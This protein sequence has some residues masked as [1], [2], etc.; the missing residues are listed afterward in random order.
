MLYKSVHVN[1]NSIVP[2]HRAIPAPSFL[3]LSSSDFQLSTLNGL[4][5]SLF[6]ATLTNTAQLVE[7]STT[8]SPAFATLT[9]FAP[10]NFFVCHSYKK[11]PGV[12]IQMPAPQSRKK[13]NYK[14]ARTNSAKD[15][16]RCAHC[17]PSGRRCKMPVAAPGQLL[18][19]MHTQEL[20]RAD[21]LNLREALLAN[22]QGLQTAQGINLALGNIFK[23]LA[24]NYISARRASVLT[25]ICSQLL[26]TLPA[27]DADKAMGITDPTAPKPAPPAAAEAPSIAAPALAFVATPDANSAAQFTAPSAKVAPPTES[28]PESGAASANTALPF[29]VPTASPASASLQPNSFAPPTGAADQ[30]AA[31]LPAPYRQSPVQVTGH[32]Q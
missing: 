23:L 32:Q 18:C 20:I 11:T 13:M 3:D 10:P 2:S 25:F 9:N 29:V 8:S 5:V 14:S 28:A 15:S 17:T 6:P 12:G 30:P 4:P 21:G 26:R 24:A 22:S 16:T 31:A 7:N 19:G 1:R 27:I